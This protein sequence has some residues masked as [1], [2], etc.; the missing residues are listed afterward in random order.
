MSWSN[1]C[2]C[3]GP[4]LD[5]GLAPNWQLAIISTN[6]HPVLL[7]MYVSQD[8]KKM[9]HCGPVMPFDDIDLGLHWLM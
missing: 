8:K 2:E 3:I 4:L 5:G 9:T 7:H 6:D 1:L